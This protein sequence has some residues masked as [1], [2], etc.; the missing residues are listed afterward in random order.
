[1]SQF[2]GKFDFN[3]ILL[4]RLIES[5]KKLCNNLFLFYEKRKAADVATDLFHQQNL[6]VSQSREVHE[7]ERP[8][9][10]FQ[11]EFSSIEWLSLSD[12]P[13]FTFHYRKIWVSFIYLDPGSVHKNLSILSRNLSKTMKL[14]P[15]F[16]TFHEYSSRTRSISFRITNSLSHKRSVNTFHLIT[17]GRHFSYRI[18]LESE[19]N[20]AELVQVNSQFFRYE[21]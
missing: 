2:W 16:K 6:F 3:N 18:I 20:S 5:L 8:R 17:F 14:L 21:Y 11:C 15:S 1:M 19:I 9:S 10:M 12:A 13:W 7:A 4:I